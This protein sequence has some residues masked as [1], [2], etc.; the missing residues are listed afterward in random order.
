MRNCIDCTIK[1]TEENRSA[2]QPDIRCTKCFAAFSDGVGDVLKKM[3]KEKDHV[4]MDTFNFESKLTISVKAATKMEAFKKFMIFVMALKK[5]Y[6]DD[7]FVIGVRLPLISK[8]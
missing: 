5:E 8:V 6:S 2:H 1:L 7:N 3:I 4:A